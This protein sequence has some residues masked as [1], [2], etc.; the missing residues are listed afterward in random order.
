MRSHIVSGLCAAG[1]TILV[2]AAL[3][4]ASGPKI[5]PILTAP[6]MPAFF[7][8]TSLGVRGGPDGMP[9]MLYVFGLSFLYWWI[10]ID[11]VWRI[12]RWVT[13]PR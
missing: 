1:L 11:L 8:A 13:N 7:L 5:D 10:V 3:H 9:S 12:W 6:L 4:F 2:A